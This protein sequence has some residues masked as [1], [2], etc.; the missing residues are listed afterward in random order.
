M[1]LL[2]GNATASALLQPARN[3]AIWSGHLGSPGYKGRNVAE[4]VEIKSYYVTS[5]ETLAHKSIYDH[6]TRIAAVNKIINAKTSKAPPEA[7]N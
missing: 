6:L 4:W 5:K 7:K 3:Y 1:Y 2:G